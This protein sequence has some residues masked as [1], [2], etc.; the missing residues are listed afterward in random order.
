MKKFK[1]L[2]LMLALALFFVGAMGMT[3]AS[4]SDLETGNQVEEQEPTTTPEE[5]TTTPTPEEPTT[6]PTPEEPTTTPTPSE[7][8]ADITTTVNYADETIEVTCGKQV[9]YQVVKAADQKTGLKTANWIKAAAKDG[10]YYID[11]SGTANSKDAFFALTTDNAKDAASVV[12]TVDAVIKSVKVTLNY[13]TEVVENG[14]A[15]VITGLNVKGVDK[16]DDNAEGKAADYSLLWKR[17]ANGT[18][19]EANEFDTLTWDMLKASNGTLYVAI[20]GKVAE[21]KTTDFRLSKE[22]KVKIPKSAKAPTVKVDYVKGTVALKNGMQVRVNG[23]EDWLDVIAYDKTGADKGVFALAKDNL[24]TNVKVSNV[25]VSDFLAAV[26]DEKLLNLGVEDGAEISIEVR[27]AATDKKF[28]SMIGNMKLVLP[29]AAPAVLTAE[30]ALEVSYTAADKTA[31]VEA[32]YELD[33]TKL[34][35]LP[36]GEKYSQYEYIFVANKADGVN[37][38]KQKWTK[39]EEDGKVDLAKYIGKDYKYFKKDATSASVVKYE[40]IKA[41]Y[42][43]LAAVKATKEVTGVF[44]SDYGIAEV[45]VT[46]AAAATPTPTPGEQEPEVTAYK[47]TWETVENC[48]VAVTYG[49]ESTAVTSGTTEIAKGETVT[50]TLTETEGYTATVAGTYGEGTALTITEGK[51][52]MPEGAVTLTITV[53]ADNAGA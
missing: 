10:K 15:D 45:N 25:A 14:L 47:I 6:T 16:G 13:K 43:R 18:W 24:K 7:G 50:V 44:A 28:P 37:L 12:A 34:F 40:A 41:V 3:K 5:P 36:E 19:T 39:L 31:K 27:T 52:T 21:D 20:D 30:K 4:A 9:Y 22:A 48:T 17:G 26:N 49:T 33:F 46:K 32:A 29:K 53:T 42:I 35:T 8:S 23:D 51:F 11:F 38:A 1:N 2:M